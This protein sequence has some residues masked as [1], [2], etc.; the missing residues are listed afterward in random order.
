MVA[1]PST[2]PKTPIIYPSSDGQP[3]AETFD[4][5]YA[6]LTTLEVLKQYLKNRRATV[7][8][9]QILYYAQ[10]LPKIY[11]VPDIMV[12]FDVEP[13]GRDSYKL[14][15]EGQAPR[16]IFEITSRGTK[17]NDLV[18]KKNLYAGLEVE[19]YWLF[20]PKNE[21]IEGQLQGYRLHEG[22]YFPILDNCSTAL[23]LRL[24]AEGKLIGFYREDNGEKLLIPEELSQALEEATSAKLQAEE[25]AEEERQLAEQERQRAEQLEEQ[26]KRYQERFGSLSESD[27]PST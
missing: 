12:I 25:Q 15:E 1:S 20:D 27:S 10:G 19:E 21:W 22:T 26:L 4:H 17:D 18:F 5:L 24:E 9:N 7:L 3:V 23:Q 16:V 11:V 8:G 14:W 2:P 6:L 13:G